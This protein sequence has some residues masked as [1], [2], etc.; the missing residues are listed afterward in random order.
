M[1]V[2]LIQNPSYGLSGRG[3]DG[4]PPAPA[5]RHADAASPSG[6][7]DGAG[8][9]PS[10][11]CSSVTECAKV[12]PSLPQRPVFK[13][14]EQIFVQFTLGRGCSSSSACAKPQ[15][16]S[17]VHRPS[18]KKVHI[19]VLWN[20][21]RKARAPALNVLL[22][23]SPLG[24]ATDDIPLSKPS[25]EPQADGG[26]T[27][28]SSGVT[29]RL[30]AL[31]L[32]ESPLKSK[33]VWVRH[34]SKS[35]IWLLVR[36]PTS[37]AASRAARSWCISKPEVAAEV[38]VGSLLGPSPLALACLTFTLSRRNLSLEWAKGHRSVEHDPLDASAGHSLVHLRSGAARS[39]EVVCA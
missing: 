23:P 14:R 17:L 10:P 36:V 18:L 31:R 4:K 20:L 15:L 39:S 13:S 5:P 19:L 33:V 25:S 30:K 27:L 2:F 6:F 8:W 32:P 3:L 37:G 21:L 24:G 29:P 16:A 9:A 12:Q 26:V 22:S 28:A 7:S 35:S 38:A 34:S 1:K 11:G